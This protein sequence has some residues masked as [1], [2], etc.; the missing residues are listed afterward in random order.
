MPS[1]TKEKVESQTDWARVRQIYESDAPI[2][3]EPGDGPYDPNDEA[4]TEAFFKEAR[5][6][7][8]YR[9]K[10]KKPTKQ[11][12]PI[13]LSPAVLAHF[14]SQGKGWQT[15]IDQALLAVV[16]QQTKADPI[17]QLSAAQ[18]KSR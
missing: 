4:A 3:F 8:G 16:E 2:P 15:R 17:S 14:K 13:R 11:L 1:T 5:V 10:Q 12:V 18:P 9:G 7:H 6:T